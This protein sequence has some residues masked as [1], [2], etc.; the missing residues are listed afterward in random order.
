MRCL[1]KGCPAPALT[2]QEY[3]RAHLRTPP[4]KLPPPVQA[5]SEYDIVDFSAVPT[6][7][8]LNEKSY[9]IAKAISVL[10]PGKA[11]RVRAGDKKAIARISSSVATYGRRLGVKVRFRSALG[12][13]YFWKDGAAKPK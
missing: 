1:E 12:F 8:V 7:R 9:G 2:D 13:V 4:T 3:C 11:L 6:I 10:G 5:E